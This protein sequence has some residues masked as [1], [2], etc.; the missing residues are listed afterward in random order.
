MDII[1][2]CYGVKPSSELFKKGITG[3]EMRVEVDSEMFPVKTIAVRH[4]FK[5]KWGAWK[6]PKTGKEV[7]SCGFFGIDEDFVNKSEVLT[8]LTGY[9]EEPM[10]SVLLK[11][12]EAIDRL[13]IIRIDESGD[14]SVVR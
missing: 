13:P 14:Y 8:L 7:E 2:V 3:C 5:N 1:H 11:I 9:H 6:D 12:M 10:Y 4:L